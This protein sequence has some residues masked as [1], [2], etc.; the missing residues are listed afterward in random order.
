MLLLISFLKY[1]VQILGN[2]FQIR[3]LHTVVQTMP[4]TLKKL[5]HSLGLVSDDWMTGF[6]VCSLFMSIKIVLSHWVEEL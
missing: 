2:A 5:Q 6:V 1:F 3:N 4:L